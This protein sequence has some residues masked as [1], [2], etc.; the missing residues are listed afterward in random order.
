MLARQVDLDYLGGSS[1]EPYKD[2]DHK[3]LCVSIR[4]DKARRRMSDYWKF[5]SSLL[6]QLELMLKQELSGAIIG[7]CWWGKLKNSTR[8]FATN[9]SRRLGNRAKSS[10]V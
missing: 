3:M 6:D 10:K 4:L 2:S 7:N 5:N 1:F 9:N 8:S